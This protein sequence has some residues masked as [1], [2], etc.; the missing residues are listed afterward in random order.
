MEGVSGDGL[1]LPGGGAVVGDGLAGASQ[2]Q[3]TGAERIEQAVCPASFASY[4]R[5]VAGGWTVSSP[6]LISQV[7]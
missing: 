2:S 3:E 7:R 1:D 4:L 6:G 5:L